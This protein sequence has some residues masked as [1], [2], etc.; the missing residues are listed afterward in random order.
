MGVA[1]RTQVRIA[2]LDG[3]MEDGLRSHYP[4]M[5]ESEGRIYVVYSKFYHEVLDA[6]R[7]DLGIHLVEVRR[8][9]INI[10]TSPKELGS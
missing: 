7:T 8:V 2:R 1:G 3:E 10:R 9:L 6:N 4:T 5:V